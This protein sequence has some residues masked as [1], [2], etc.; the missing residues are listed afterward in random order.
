MKRK[1]NGK[2]TIVIPAYN[3]E[4]IVE[5]VLAEVVK[6]YSKQ[7]IILVDDGST[8]K[9]YEMTRK[10]EGIK[11]IRH[12][13]NKGYGAALKTGIRNASNETVVLMDGD[14]QHN[15]QD[16]SRLAKLI[17][18]YDMVVGARTKDSEVSFFRQSGK[19]VLGLL[20][21]YLAGMKIPDLNSGFRAVRKDVALR[22]MHI[23]PNT[24][25]FTTTI[26]LA[27]IKDGYSIKYEPVKT[28]KR[29]GKSKIKPFRNG[30]E[31]ILLILRTIVLFDP[32]K[33]FLPAS[34]LFLTA[35][36]VDA[37]YYLILNTSVSKSALLLIFS[38]LLIFCFGLLADQMSA[39]RR[40]GR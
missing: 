6:R 3:E 32:L 29:V 7:E 33:V 15:P 17:G 34:L 12:P 13:Y 8:D 20:A 36:T 27:L 4:E 37:L 21:N 1:D 30:F 16:I 28:V 10:V 18:D 2:F 31:F 22:H 25:S 9:T 40:E 35:G 24:F 19:K 39:M 5:S 14:G 23:L 38:G 26:T 11:I